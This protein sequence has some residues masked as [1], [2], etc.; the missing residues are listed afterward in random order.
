MQDLPEVEP[1]FKANLPEDVKDRVSFK[2]HNF[3]EPQ[4]VQADIYLLKMI[5]HD[6]PDEQ[7]I[8]ILQALRPGLRTGSRVILFEYIGNQDEENKKI[9]PR[10]MQHM[11]TATD[12]RI[13]GLF[14]CEE[15]KVEAW[16]KLFTQADERFHVINVKADPVTFF[17]VI[18]AEWRE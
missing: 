10:T 9:L 14:N 15:R 3:Y 17:A 1:V 2:V 5:L 18:E 11:G 8:K 16:A 4:T 6:W 13:M 7:S 12:I